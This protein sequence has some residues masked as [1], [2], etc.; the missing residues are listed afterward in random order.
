MSGCR[1]AHLSEILARGRRA[2]TRHSRHTGATHLLQAGVDITVIAFWL[3]HESTQTTHGYIEADLA[4][5]EKALRKVTPAGQKTKRGYR[6][7]SGWAI[8]AIGHN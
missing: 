7:G 1:F 4:L 3:G 6:W 8:Q 2:G 5:K